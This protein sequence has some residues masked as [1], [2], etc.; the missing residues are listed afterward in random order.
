M[1]EIDGFDATPEQ[2]SVRASVR[3]LARREF[4]PTYLTRAQS[5]DFP[6]KAL[7]SLSELGLLQ[8]LC[9]PEH[10]GPDEPAYVAS[11]IAV[12]ELAYADFNIANL[13]I[14]PLIIS[15]ILGQFGSSELQQSWLPP[16][17]AGETYVAL[18]LTEPELGSDAAS[19][20]TKATRVADGWLISGEKTS[21]TAVP[22]AQ[23]C[24]VFARTGG[25]GASGVSAFLVPLDSA[26]VSQAAIPDPGWKPVGRGSIA[27]EDVHVPDSALIGGE[28]EAFSTV[29][30]GFDFTRPLLALTAI[31]AAQ[32]SIDDAAA[33]V[34]QRRAFGAPL[35]AY[36]GVSFPLAEH[37]TRLV[38]A[39]SLCYQALQRRERGQPHTALAAMV[40]WFGPRSAMEAAHDCMLLL[41]HYG[42]TTD[43]PME[44]RLRDIMA[45][46]IADGTAQIQ[47]IIIARELFGRDFV[48]YRG[49]GGTAPASGKG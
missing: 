28:G 24:I 1:S 5:T 46:E 16:L 31:G 10:G 23:A 38:A 44:Q 45:V 18:G 2:E 11:G 35:A 41:G 17:T 6:W 21:I 40:K 25:G 42:Y 30:A 13:L 8:L 4:G 39:R 7:R 29:M 33:Y 26:D 9:P 15:Y 3:S 20:R 12:E 36:E 32:A 49:S 48:P 47:K 34:R 19:L 22:H 43:N 27:F 14:P 37:A